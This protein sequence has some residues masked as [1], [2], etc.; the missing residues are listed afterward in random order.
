MGTCGIAAGARD[1][2]AVHA[3]ELARPAVTNV[4]LR[5]S[6]CAGLCE[7]EP[8][9]T[10]TRQERHDYRYGQLDKAKV[11]EIV[12]EHLVG[13]TPVET[14]YRSS[15][16]LE[17]RRKRIWSNT[18]SHVLVCTGGGCIASGAL[19][20]QAPRFSEELWTSRA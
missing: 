4:T 6:G 13:G 12:R 7:Q 11:D 20:V 15:K 2:L 1:V 16:A 14:Q 17:A 8:M 3:D 9:I 19:A 18:R 10:V 5:Q